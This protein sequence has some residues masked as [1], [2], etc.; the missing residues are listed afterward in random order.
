MRLS[1]ALALVSMFVSA[2]VF[3]AEDDD[4][5]GKKKKKGKEEEGRGQGRRRQHG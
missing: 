3:G 1:F 4:G 2:P 5:G